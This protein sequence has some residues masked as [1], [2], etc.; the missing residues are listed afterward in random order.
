MA[1]KQKVG[2]IQT[3]KPRFE[4]VDDGEFEGARFYDRQAQQVEQPTQEKTGFLRTQGDRALALGQGVVGGVKMLSDLAGP[5]NSVSQTLGQA[6]EGMQKLYSPARMA[7]MGARLDIINQA[8]EGGSTLDQIT[9]RL[10]GIAEA[11]LQTALQAAGSMAPNIAAA[12]ATGGVSAGPGLAALAARIG[13][14]AVLGVGMGVGSVK[15]QNFEAV[16]QKAKQSGMDDDQATA[17]AVKASEYS[18][19]NAP[20]QALGGALGVLD[21]MTGAERMISGMARKEGGKQGILKRSVMGGLQE[22]PPEGLQGAQGQYAQ[23]EAMNNTGFQTD[24]WAGVAGQGVNDAVVGA[25][26]G[27]P[28]GAMNSPAKVPEVGP[29]S[30]AANTGIDNTPPAPAPTPPVPLAP[31]QEQSLLGHAN[32]RAQELKDKA[33]GTKGQKVNAPDGTPVTIPGKQPEFL[34]P[35]EKEERD[36]LE[37]NG[38]DAQ[39]LATAYPGMTQAPAVEQVPQVPQEQPAQ[40]EQVPVVDPVLQVPKVEQVPLETPSQAEQVPPADPVEVARQQYRREQAALEAQAQQ[41]EEDRINALIEQDKLQQA[42]LDDNFWAGNEPLVTDLKNPKGQ[43]FKEKA[44]AIAA[45]NRAGGGDVVAV[46]GGFVVRSNPQPTTLGTQTNAV[47]GPAFGV[48]TARGMSNVKDT[49]QGTKPPAIEAPGEA[50]QAVAGNAAA[51]N[52]IPAA[53]SAA[54]EGVWVAK[55]ETPDDVATREW[56]ANYSTVRGSIKS[57]SDKEIERA[58]GYASKLIAGYQKAAFAGD[59]AAKDM[60]GSIQAEQAGFAQEL[61]S[62]KPPATPAQSVPIAGT[63]AT[64]SGT[65]ATSRPALE[66]EKPTD[67]GA[68]WTRMPQAD[69]LALTTRAGMAKLIADKI[70]RTPWAE[71]TPKTRERIVKAMAMPV[72]ATEAAQEGPKAPVQTEPAKKKSPNQRIA[73]SLQARADYFAPGNI[74]TSYGGYDEV[75]SYNPPKHDGSGWS[76]KV[77]AVK[78]VNGEWVRIGKPQDARTHSTQPDARAL[79]A[80]P[81]AEVSGDVSY[82]EPRADGKPF[83]N[84]PARPASQVTAGVSAVT[85]S[86]VTEAEAKARQAIQAA[87]DGMDGPA[88]QQLAKRFLPTMGM[89]VPIGKARIKV[90]MVDAKVNLQA[91]ASEAGVSLPESMN[92]ALTAKAEGRVGLNAPDAPSAESDDG[93]VIKPGKGFIVGKF[94]SEVDGDGVPGG[95]FE[96]EVSARA[97][98]EAWRERKADRATESAA[99]RARRDAMAERIKAGAEPTANEIKSLDLAS[100]ESDIRW[101]FPT[102]ANLF[103]LTSRQIRPMVAAMIRIASNDMGTKREL[104]PT[105]NAL[106]AIG[107]TLADVKDQQSNTKEAAAIRPIGQEPVTPAKIEDFGEKLAG[108]RKDYAALMKDAEAVDISAEPL[109]KSWPEPDYQKLLEGGADPFVVAWAHAGRDEIPTRPQSSWKLSNWAAQVKMLRDISFKLVNGEISKDKLLETLGRDEFKRVRDHVGN[110]AELYQAVGHEKSLKGVTFLEHHYSLYKGERNVTKWAI[111]QPSKATAFGNWPREILSANTRDEALREFKLKYAGLDLGSKAKAKPG[112]IIYRKRGQDGAFVGKKIGR[113]YIDLHK[114]GDIKAARAYMEANADAL[115]ALLAKYK[116]TPYERNAENAPRVGGDHRNGA[117]VT[118]EVFANTFGF[119]GVQF[120][121]YVEQG[122]RQSDLNEAFDALMDMAAVLGVPPRAISLNGRLGLA[123]GARGKGGK[124]APA[125]HYEG[126]NMVINLTKG[127]GPGSLAHEWF[128]AMDNYFALTEGGVGGYITGGATSD[129][130]RMEMRAAFVAIKRAVQAGALK[131]RSEELD[132][133]RTKPYWATPMEMAARSFE[134]YIIAKLQDQSASNDY[135]ANI[136]SQQAW[137]VSDAMRL[138][139]FSDKGPASSY[140]Y[141]TVDEMP[142]IRAAFDDFFKTVETRDTGDGKVAMFATGGAA[143]GSTIAEVEQTLGQLTDGM[144][145]APLGQVVQSASDLPFDAPA[146]AKGAYWRGNIYL[147]ADNIGSEQDARDVIAHEMIGHYGLRGFFGRDLADVLDQIHASNPQVRIAA[148]Q[149]VRDN[150]A[151]ISEWQSKYGTTDEQVKSRSI[152]EAMSG[153]AEKGRVLKGLNRLAAIL[154]TLLRKM[155]ASKWADALEAKTDAEA[156]LALK[157]AEM[158]VRRGVTQASRIP[159]AVYPL[160][161][162]AADTPASGLNGGTSATA[163]TAESG[164]SATQPALSRSVLVGYTQ[165]AADKLNEVFS[166]PGKLSLWDKTVGSMYHLAER[167]PVFKQVFTTAQNFINDVS[168]YAAESADLAPKILPK[169]DAWKDMLKTPVSA[170]DNKA[171]AAP[172]L[173]GTLSWARDEAGNAVRIETLEEAAKSLT[174]DQKSQRL[175][176]GDHI[177]ESVLKMWRGLPVDQYEAMIAKRFET[178]MLKPGIVFTDVELVDHFKLNPAQISL[179]REFRAATDKSLDNLAKADL[180]RFGGKDAEPLKD[181]VMGAKTADE[182]AV[183]L[184]DYL[185]SQRDLMPE[186]ADDLTA[187]AGGMIERADKVNALKK[188]GYAPLSRFG[189]YSVDV[190]VDGKREYFN[191][192]ESKAA[193]NQMAVKMKQTFGPEN[194]AQGTM[195]QKEFEQFQGITPES[196]ELFGNKLGLD[197]TGDDAQDKAFQAYLKLTKTNRSAMKRMIHRQGVAGYS[198]DMGRVLAAFVYSNARQTSAALHMG[199][200]GKAVQDIPKGQGELKDAAIELAT[201]IKQPREEAQ[202]LRG[203][204]FAQYLGGSIASAFVNFTQPL[205]VSFPYLSQYGGAQKAGAALI[206][207]MKD[208]R[209]G[210]KFEKGLAEA[211]RQA[212]EKGTTQPQSVHELMAQ[213]QGLAVMNSGDGTRAGDAKAFMQNNLSKLVL[214]WGKLF[215][216]AEQVNRRSTFIAAYRLAV[217]QSIA[218]PGGFA[219]K[220]VNETQFVSNKANKAKFARGAIGSTLMT[221]KSYSVNYLEL[222]HRMATQ[223]GPEGKKAAALM[224]GMLMLMAGAGGL[225]F[226]DDLEDVTDMMAQ[227]MGYNFSA[228]KAKQE[229]LEDLFGKAMA[230]FI[231]KGIS[232]L[233]GSPIDTSGRMTMGNLIPGTGFLLTKRDHASDAQELLGPTGDL[234]KRAFNGGKSVLAGDFYQGAKTLAPKAL[235]NFEKGADMA[236]TGNYNDDRGYKVIEATPFEAAMKAIGFQPASVAEVQQS[237]YL[238]QRAKDFYSLNTQA[239]NARWAKGI[240]EKDPAQIE[241]ARAMVQRWNENN[242]DQRIK[243]NMPAILK[244]V[245]DMRK[246]KDERIADTAPKAM[247][248]QMRQEVMQAREAA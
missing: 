247:R 236:V 245:K 35:S 186:R 105:K 57:A 68:Q 23:N 130:L 143:T 211:L 54:L 242:P 142:A 164:T 90:A 148:G 129:K 201:Y 107:R 147:V 95:P 231:D 43:P 146:D 62:R 175:L 63:S 103:G 133:R 91:A 207:A 120:G 39:A 174:V 232:G 214:G 166:H 244:R 154:Q 61:A 212:D 191:L 204:L 192:F 208:Q 44:A 127:G 76:V 25:M 3:T 109:S 206:Q 152:E 110:R 198:E 202:A 125:A 171:I 53:G 233:P 17:L 98:A 113:E 108:A 100:P 188:Q 88:V 15:G 6:N 122:R 137:D 117:P 199:A 52:D 150:Q 92:A 22:A 167:S 210:V 194:V 158:F 72:Q 170:L 30:R 49:A 149:W 59:Q 237:N 114:A 4:F 80:G 8:D 138:G 2:Q 220:V 24:P 239:I 64:E 28:V 135:L 203:L 226:E 181:M 227:W 248:A 79:K 160:L 97:A 77:H 196:L 190:V 177:S 197:S 162:R 168:F 70:A 16:F 1:T 180:L 218:D 230:Q 94:I 10:G 223:N 78:K 173:Q 115:E 176:R 184:R 27:A 151:L 45:K 36:F 55:P 5:D 75:I 67:D 102:A 12:L 48:N 69:R 241:D 11:P 38:G 193:A 238:N 155:G 136:V 121:N 213:A 134:S 111:E 40:M 9:S 116:D 58:D 89:K 60:I 144:K 128:H 163:P 112:F 41:A 159:D 195:S 187:A 222:L 157:K 31:E 126:G 19:Q 47:A 34:T 73:E 85:E 18:A 56:A 37:Q 20:Q 139:D 229:F 71:I 131:L 200:L 81:L 145:N 50:P 216:L 169:L 119:R 21:S 189:R 118:P 132:K 234:I 172:I 140:P 215:G 86:E 221:F 240:Y 93:I 182:A 84:V 106:M 246:S 74:I 224:L 65:S 51:T 153:F 83:P 29:M 161:S 123:F 7:E 141:P 243:A 14:P 66:A 228:K 183:M 225:P 32:L 26:V 156:L 217:E 104:V 101:F 96:T 205:T 209:A 165:H 185:H 124:N 179:Y 33:S 87:I 42:Q 178:D 46:A 13:V 235:Y 219:T 99:E 82:T